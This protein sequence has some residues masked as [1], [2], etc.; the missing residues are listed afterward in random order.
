MPVGLV[1]IRNEASYRKEFFCDGLKAA[2]YT[3]TQNVAHAPKPDDVLIVWNRHGAHDLYARR[4][5]TAGA[6][7]IVAENGWIGKDPSGHKL[8]AMCLGHHCGRGTW[9]VGEGDRWSRIGVELKPWRK[10]GK[11]ILVL[12]ARGIGER[13]LAQPRN[14]IDDVTKRLARVTKRPV[15]VRL[16]PGLKLKLNDA[17]MPPLAPDLANCWAAVTWASGAGIK[18]IVEGV[19]VFHDLPGWIGAAA[20]RH[21]V[22]DIENPFL[23]DRIPMLQRMAWCMWSAEEIATGEPIKRLLKE[24]R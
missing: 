20:A 21:G 15:R 14:W 11:H 17:V 2:G 7:V 18:S 5:E 9:R 6:K 1:V 13:G 4:F 19:P 22:D 10:D 24:W 8:Y 3:L 23:G 12:A 16:H